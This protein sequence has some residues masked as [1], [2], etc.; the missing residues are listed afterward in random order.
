MAG[1]VN[2]EATDFTARE[3]TA[4]KPAPGGVMLG[5]SYAEAPAL[6]ALASPLHHLRAGAPPFLFVDGAN[7]QP[8]QR[9][10]EFRPKLRQLG[11]SEQMIVLPEAPHGMWNME[12]WF[13]DVARHLTNFFQEKLQAKK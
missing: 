4:R 13:P 10:A 7:D 9:Y 1:P 8:E 6:Y 5:K 2:L 11:I 3:G 12:G